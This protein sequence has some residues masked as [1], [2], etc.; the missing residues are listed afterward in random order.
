MTD[1]PT[2]AP[3]APWDYIG[4]P[5]RW[6]DGD[7]DW[8]DVTKTI[9][10]D[11]GFRVTTET[12]VKH[13]LEFRLYGCDTPERGKPN[14]KE[15]ADFCRAH[16]PVG[17]PVKVKTYKPRPEDK[18]GRWLVQIINDDGTTSDQMLIAAGLAVP[19]FGGHKG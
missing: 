15:A 8:M 16:W 13:H 1:T 12:T 14:Y 7:T 3:D 4:V 9:E 5:A 2:P 19:Y 17:S 11:N 10:I 6:V 18:Y